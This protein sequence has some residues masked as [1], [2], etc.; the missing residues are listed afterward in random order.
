MPFLSDVTQRERIPEL[1]DDAT[2]DPAEHRRALRGLARL[3]RLSGSAEILWPRI[4]QLART[5]RQTE[6]RVLDVAT[7]AGDIPIRLAEKARNAGYRNLSFH[8]CDIS[9]VAVDTATTAVSTRDAQLPVS[10]F[11][12]DVLV[13]PLP[14]QYD[15]VTC[16]LFLH[17]LDQADA[18][19]LLQRMQQATSRFLLVND[20]ARSAWNH[21]L[22]WVTSRILSRSPI[23]HFDGPASVRS[24]FT[25]DEAAALA[26]EAGLAGARVFDR[27]P[28]RFLLVW[29]R[30]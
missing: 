20:L 23:V 21:A 14:Q 5:H 6:I 4:A 24:A 19:L 3:N 12:H 18:R 27:L 26:Q 8:G 15:I 2:L 16:S 29:S 11:T 28:C 30:S 17:H 1:M 7:G 9:P 22:V 13:H 25:P 10:F